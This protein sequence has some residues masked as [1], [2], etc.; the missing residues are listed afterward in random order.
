MINYIIYG[1][2]GM[3]LR[4]RRVPATAFNGKRSAF[5]KQHANILTQKL[6]YNILK[7]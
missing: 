6:L 1:C 7:F 4:T 3:T 5:Y 2:A